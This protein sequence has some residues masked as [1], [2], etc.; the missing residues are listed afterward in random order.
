MSQDGKLYLPFPV[1]TWRHLKSISIF[2]GIK[3][4]LFP[5][6]WG[7]GLP[8]TIGLFR[9]EWYRSDE[10]SNGFL[11]ISIVHTSIQNYRE[12]IYLRPYYTL[13]FVQNPPT[14]QSCIWTIWEKNWILWEKLRR[15]REKTP[16][17]V[18]KSFEITL[19][20][21]EDGSNHRAGYA[22]CP[23]R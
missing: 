7:G 2:S 19:F 13:D 4:G 15:F 3:E 11:L 17:P 9:L 12:S 16:R 20:W 1:Y 8:N 14:F 10:S 22:L 21:P 23:R 18:K 6:L 5:C